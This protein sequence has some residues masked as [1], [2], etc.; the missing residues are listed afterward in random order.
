[1]PI[2]RRHSDPLIELS[3]TSSDAPVDS[4]VW[5]L[6]L[7]GDTL[8][9]KLANDASSMRGCKLRIERQGTKITRVLVNESI[10]TAEDA[11]HAANIEQGN[12][13]G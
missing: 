13:T 10:W 2:W 6:R 8:E 1:M 9:I 4:R 11:V 12:S 3:L 5:E 7:E